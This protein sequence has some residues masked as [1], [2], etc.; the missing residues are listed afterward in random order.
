MKKSRN[1]EKE[2]N[3]NSRIEIYKYLKLKIYQVDL[4]ADLQLQTERP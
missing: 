2:P 3:E 4:I 1:S